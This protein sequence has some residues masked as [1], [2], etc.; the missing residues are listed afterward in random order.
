MSEGQLRFW[1]AWKWPNGE[2]AGGVDLRRVVAVLA[3]A[4]TVYPFEVL[5]D[6]NPKP[7]LLTLEQFKAFSDAWAAYLNWSPEQTGTL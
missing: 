2:V 6:F 7:L 1:F 3:R 4:D 5:L